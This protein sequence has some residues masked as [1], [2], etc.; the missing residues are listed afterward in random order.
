[1]NSFSEEELVAACRNGDKSAY[2][3]LVRAYSARVFAIC[4]GT[5][6]NAHDAEDVAQQALFKGFTDI[7]KLRDGERFGVW[8][9]QIARNLCIDFV[10]KKHR[11]RDGLSRPIPPDKSEGKD[12][13]EELEAALARLAEDYRIALLLYYFDG[14]TTRHM[15][16]TLGISEAAVHTRLSRARKKLRQLLEREG[17]R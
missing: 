8:L 1:M 2:A 3:D 14:R 5:L 12:R 17:D 7:K 11:R 10:R 6:V 16:E 13:E 15:A 9:C 4:L